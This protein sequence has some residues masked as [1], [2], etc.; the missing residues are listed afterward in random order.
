MGKNIGNIIPSEPEPTQSNLNVWRIERHS[1]IHHC[2]FAVLMS[3]TAYHDEAD[4][5]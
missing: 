4:D 2:V 1:P 3:F 5:G